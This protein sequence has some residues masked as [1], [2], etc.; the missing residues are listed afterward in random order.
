VIVYVETNF[1]LELALQRDEAKEADALLALAEAGDIK[2]VVP[3]FSL[4]EARLAL[5]T[6]TESRLKFQETLRAQIRELARSASF[7]DLPETSAGLAKALISSSAL[8]ATALDDVA[9]RIR[10]HAEVIPVTSELDLGT[11]VEDG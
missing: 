10:T 11:G 3:A 6:M 4:A 9:N 5:Q 7:S 8:H 1:I 2:M